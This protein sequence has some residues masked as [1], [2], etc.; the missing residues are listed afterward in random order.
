MFSRHLQHAAKQGGRD[1]L[2]GKLHFIPHRIMHKEDP[3]LPLVDNAD[4]EVMRAVISRVE[5]AFAPRDRE[6]LKPPHEA[7]R[8]PGARGPLALR[9]IR[10]L[11]V[12]VLLPDP[13]VPSVDQ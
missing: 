6:C 1:P 13:T 5:P 10:V 9:R 3:H 8:L 4:V 7:P 11:T 2:H 12:R